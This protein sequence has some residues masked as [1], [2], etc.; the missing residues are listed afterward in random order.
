[1][2]LGRA[3]SSSTAIHCHTLRRHKASH[4]GE[5]IASDCEADLT[6]FDFSDMKPV[7]F[8]LRPKDERLTIRLPAN[9]LATLKG[10]AARHKMPYGRFIRMTLEHALKR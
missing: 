1:M 5:W 6:E 8:E 4:T 9:L 3:C 10:E 2:L 7:R